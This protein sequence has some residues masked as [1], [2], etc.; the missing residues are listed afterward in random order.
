MKC[1]TLAWYPIHT[2][3]N[4]THKTLPTSSSTPPLYKASM[5]VKC[6]LPTLELSWSSYLLPRP[7]PSVPTQVLERPPPRSSQSMEFL[8]YGEAYKFSDPRPSFYSWGNWDTGLEWLGHSHST[9]AQGTGW[10]PTECSLHLWRE[11][12]PD[13]EHLQSKVCVLPSLDVYWLVFLST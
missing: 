13:C 3:H 2:L 1:K 8:R 10:H 11:V 7:P 12:F 9:K 6:L 4:L 5:Q